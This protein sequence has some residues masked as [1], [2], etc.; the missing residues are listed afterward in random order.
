MTLL[1]CSAS[2]PVKFF[3]KASMLMTRICS[4]LLVANCRS[5]LTFLAS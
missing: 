3:R 4:V 5:R 2:V 1:L